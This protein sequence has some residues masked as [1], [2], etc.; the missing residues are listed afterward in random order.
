MLRVYDMEQVKKNVEEYLQKHLP[1][2]KLLE[3]RKKSAYP[4]DSYLFMVSAKNEN[5]GTF[6]VWTSWNETIQSL[7][8][9]HYNL[10]SIE[11]CEKVFD[12]FYNG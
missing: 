4:E 9:G 6:A 12:E 2:Y 7:N 3:I 1:Q 8:Y 10:Q 5:D 11:E